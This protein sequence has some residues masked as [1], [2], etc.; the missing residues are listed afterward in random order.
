MADDNNRHFMNKQMGK[1]MTG[2]DSSM[3]G[4]GKSA[5]SKK[6]HLP[7]SP[8]DS[9]K[10]AMPNI[11]IHSHDGGHT[12]HVMHHD[13]THEKHEHEA[14][15]AEGMAEHLHTHFGTGDAGVGHGQDHGYSSGSAMEDEDT[16]GGSGV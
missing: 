16:L 14:G 12:V 10:H 6:P 3:G 9:G 2:K 1:H 8:H 11:H 4:H 5:R 13:G 7:D 15:D